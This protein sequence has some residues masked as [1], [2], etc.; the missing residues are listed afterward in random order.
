MKQHILSQ[1]GKEKGF[2][3]NSFVYYDFER[4]I[5]FRDKQ[6]KQPVVQTVAESS[7]IE[8]NTIETSDP[9]EFYFNGITTI[10]T[11]SKED[12]DP[13][14]FICVNAAYRGDTV[15]TYSIE[16]SDPDEFVAL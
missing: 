8:T 2:S 11:R 5:S 14:C 7:S 13:D 9:D 12:S 10:D 3:Y 1:Y 15:Y 6:M 4:Q 16:D